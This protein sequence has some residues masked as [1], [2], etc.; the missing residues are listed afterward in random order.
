MSAGYAVL[1]SKQAHRSPHGITTNTP[2]PQ[3]VNLKNH[4]QITPMQYKNYIIQPIE[5]WNRKQ[6]EKYQKRLDAR[7][8]NEPFPN[9]AFY[10]F[11]DDAQERITTN[12]FVAKHISKDI[13]FAEN[14]ILGLKRKITKELAI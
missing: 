13:H 7:K 5:D 12:M 1:Y 8:P 6:E 2:Q 14:T 11:Y 9:R 10:F 3:S 4:N